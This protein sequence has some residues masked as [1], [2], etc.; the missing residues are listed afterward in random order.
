MKLKDIMTAGVDVLSPDSSLREA[1]QRMRSLNIGP[2]PVLD[3]DRVVGMLTDRDITIRATAEGRDPNT[4]Q[5]QDVMTR[6]VVCCFEDDDVKVAAKRMSESQIR[7]VLVMNRD[8]RLVGIASLGDLAVD[9]GDEKMV[10]QILEDVS[11]PAHG[12]RRG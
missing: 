4:T 9:S 10:G 7:R 5:V 6:E 1:A 11:K 12:V 3:G 8:N 2:L